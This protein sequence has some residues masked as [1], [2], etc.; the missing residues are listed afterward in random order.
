MDLIFN[1]Y[2]KPQEKFVKNIK[3]ILIAQCEHEKFK[4][5]VQIVI[6]A[7]F[8]LVSTFL[9]FDPDSKENDILMFVSVFVPCNFL[10]DMFTNCGT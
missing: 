10:I 1:F 4:K 2:I 7:S 6:M 3:P 8:W 9:I 5:K